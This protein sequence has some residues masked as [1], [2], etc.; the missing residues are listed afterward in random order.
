MAWLRSC[1]WLGWK[2][3]SWQ[4]CIGEEILAQGRAKGNFLNHIYLHVPQTYI[5][6]LFI[7][8]GLWNARGNARVNHG[9]LQNG[10]HLRLE[11]A[12]SLLIWPQFAVLMVKPMMNAPQMAN[13]GHILLATKW[14]YKERKIITTSTEENFRNSSNVSKSVPA[15]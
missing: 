15:Q 1:L 13:F 11:S 7:V 4:V 9:I 12:S 14:V 10:N 6:L 8:R 5:T 2:N 3:I